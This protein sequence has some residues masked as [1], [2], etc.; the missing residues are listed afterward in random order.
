M[1]NW[2][3]KKMAPLYAFINSYKAH[4]GVIPLSFNKYLMFY[5]KNIEEQ[6]LKLEK[7]NQKIKEIWYSPK[8]IKENF[9]SKE[10]ASQWLYH[11]I[12][13]YLIK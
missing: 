3:S 5:L 8:E 9:I 11:E 13:K 2:K 1:S 4:G 12:K 10:E 6:I 7:E